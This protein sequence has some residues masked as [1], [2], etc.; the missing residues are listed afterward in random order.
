MSTAASLQQMKEHTRSREF[1]FVS[2]SSIQ[3]DSFDMHM[4]NAHCSQSHKYQFN[5]TLFVCWMRYSASTLFEMLMPFF[6][7]Q[8]KSIC[9]KISLKSTEVIHRKSNRRE[10]RDEVE[11]GPKISAGIKVNVSSN[12]YHNY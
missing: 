2:R 1:V 8:F 11:K 7:R 12:F 6:V 10:V 4:H 3:N 5:C 9:I